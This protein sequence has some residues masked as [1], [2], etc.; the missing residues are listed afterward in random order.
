V[1]KGEENNVDRMAELNAQ[2]YAAEIEGLR[3]CVARP[4]P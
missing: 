4:T 1:D 3:G 2:I